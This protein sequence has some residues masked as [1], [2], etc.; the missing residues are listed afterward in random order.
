M[1]GMRM[2]KADEED[3]KTTHN[4]LSWCEKF[5]DNRERY[6]FRDMESDWLTWGEDDEEKQYSLKIRKDIA[7]EEGCDEEDV[8]NRLV[9]YEVIKRMYK[10]CDTN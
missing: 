8:D 3:F 4:F 5:W 6:S 1:P 7:E 10:K 9:V 2:A